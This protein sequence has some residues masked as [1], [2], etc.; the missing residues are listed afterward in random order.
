MVAYS[1][2]LGYRHAYLWPFF[3]SA[4]FQVLPVGLEVV[5]LEGH[6]YHMIDGGFLA[7]R[8]SVS[9]IEERNINL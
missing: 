2:C 5:L 3:H 6:V 4:I 9:S 7:M 1:G 8:S